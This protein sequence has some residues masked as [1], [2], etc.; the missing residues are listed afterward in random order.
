MAIDRL[1]KNTSSSASERSDDIKKANVDQAKTPKEI[2]PK[3]LTGEES[4]AKA[5]DQA[6][7]QQDKGQNWQA[8]S[9]QQQDVS[10]TPNINEIA[11][12]EQ[13]DQSSQEEKQKAVKAADL[14]WELQIQQ[15]RLKC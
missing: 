14:Q 1:D 15:Q 10:K 6:S 12:Q 7:S 3:A 9:N 8:F 2:E 5:V 13:Q 11:A 4:S